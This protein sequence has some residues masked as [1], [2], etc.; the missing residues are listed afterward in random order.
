MNSKFERLLE[1]TER[2][3][4]REV[5]SDIVLMKKYRA[6][7]EEN[8]LLKIRIEEIERENGLMRKEIAIMKE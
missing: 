6:G 4:N 5:D 7:E 8:K 3:S 2:E 1:E